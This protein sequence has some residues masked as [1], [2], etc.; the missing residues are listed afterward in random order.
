[1]TFKKGNVP[2]NKNLLGCFSQKTRKKMSI[3]IRKALKNGKMRYWQGK[4]LSKTHRDKLSSRALGRTPWNK[5]KKR[6]EIS[7]E[8]H[9][10]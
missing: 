8:N 2:W 4:H 6:P 1:M 7:G 9:Y 3:G 10:F 5:G